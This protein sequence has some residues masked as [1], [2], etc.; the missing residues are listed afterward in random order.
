VKKGLFALLI[1]LVITAIVV[2]SYIWGWGHQTQETP[3]ESL[4]IFNIEVTT[5]YGGLSPL[6]AFLSEEFPL[7]TV[8]WETNLPATSY[9]EYARTIHYLTG[10]LSPNLKRV[11]SET[12]LGTQ[13]QASFRISFSS[14]IASTGKCN[15]P[16]QITA[17]TS[18]GEIASE[19]YSCP[20]SFP[21]M[22]LFIPVP[23]EINQANYFQNIEELTV[24]FDYPIPPSEITTFRDINGNV[25]RVASWN[26]SGS[27]KMI[28]SLEAIISRKVGMTP[29]STSDPYP[30]PEN[31]LSE[32]IKRY[33]QPTAN[34]QSNNP[35][36]VELAKSLAEGLITET[37]VV[38]ATINWVN[39]NIKYTCS[40]EFLN[41]EDC[42]KY[43]YRYDP[44]SGGYHPIDPEVVGA[45]WTLKYRIG[46]CNDFANLAIAL[47]RAQ[48]I[49]ARFVE[50]IS[51]HEHSNP[52]YLTPVEDFMYH[53]AV[54]VYYPKAGWVY[55]DPTNSPTYIPYEIKIKV[56]L[57]GVDTG[58]SRIFGGVP[59]DEIKWKVV[60]LG[61]DKVKYTFTYTAE[62]PT[63]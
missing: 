43:N 29:V 25:Y 9:L 41:K 55:Y 28:A 16:I 63:E 36:I 60:G 54:E 34:S 48:G 2:P 22:M 53:A 14:S 3:I 30:V 32:D 57:D 6:Q 33:L 47:I 52:G 19:K 31:L 45:V 40:S 15:I 13:H 38:N 51:G 49:P 46:V 7:V 24:N 42:E 5:D 10:E 37:E 27:G 8:K 50:T 18:S 39:Q 11:N 44:T 26:K 35:A 17:E 1:V 59:G 4:Q 23:R 56:G 21:E 20:Y 12:N 58:P 61:D 62:I